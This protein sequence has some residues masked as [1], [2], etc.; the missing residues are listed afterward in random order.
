VL[1]VESQTA[2]DAPCPARR[3]N[4]DR[5]LEMDPEFLNTEGEHEHDSRVSTV[6]RRQEG[7]GQAPCRYVACAQSTL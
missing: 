5:V 7:W 6:S 2:P 3:F 4:L 1:Y